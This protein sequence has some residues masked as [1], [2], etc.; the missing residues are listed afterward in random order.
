MWLCDSVT[1][2]GHNLG[3][4]S[5]GLQIGYSVELD[6]NTMS[7]LGAFTGS[8]GVRIPEDWLATFPDGS[9]YEQ[10]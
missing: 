5:P 8:P 3:R 7:V 2:A 4:P 1:V 10:R 9:R 6:I